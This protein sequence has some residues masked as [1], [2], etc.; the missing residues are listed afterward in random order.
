MTTTIDLTIDQVSQIVGVPKTKLRYWETVF[1]VPIKRTEKNG[2]RY[3]QEAVDIMKKIKDLSDYGFS[4]RGIKARLE[5]KAVPGGPPPDP[6]C[7]D[8]TD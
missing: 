2:R 3:P 1:K 8:L 4:S 6:S 5:E 7:I